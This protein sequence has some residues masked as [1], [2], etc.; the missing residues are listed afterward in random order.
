MCFSATANFVASGV[1]G[2]IG[3]ATLRHVD[4]PRSVLFAATPML[5]ALHQFIE[6]FVWLGL[7]RRIGP[8]AFHHAAF[9]FILYAQGI[10]PLLMPLAVLLMEPPGWRRRGV[11]M[12]TAIG[13]LVCA[14]ATYAVIAFPSRALVEYHSIAYRNPMTDGAWV[15][16]GYVVAT[17]GALLLSTHKV[18]RWFGILNVVG[19]TI[20]MIIK[21]YAFTSVWCLYAAT[22]SIMLYW[23]FRHRHIDIDSPNSRFA[24]I[25]GEWRAFRQFVHAG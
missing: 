8:V 4:H 5:F 22:L 2:S 6:A 16:G 3:V 21:G 14:W 17:C 23:Q 11:A 9:L 15:A 12:A 19:L 18:V 7:D 13:A 10:L 1:I 25:E 20:V 24:G